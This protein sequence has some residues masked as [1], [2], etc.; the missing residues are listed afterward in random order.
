MARSVRL[1][2]LCLGIVLFGSAC[3]GGADP[4]AGTDPT[5]DP[6]G[7]NVATDDAPSSA[8]EGDFCP[9]PD[10]YLRGQLTGTV[11]ETL[12]WRS[13]AMEC[14]GSAFDAD[15]HLGWSHDISADLLLQIG[16][17]RLTPD[18]NG[19]G[20]SLPARLTINVVGTDNASYVGAA[21][22]CVV[23]ITRNEVAQ[24]HLR[25]IEG[26]ASCEP[27]SQIGGEGEITMDG[28]LAFANYV[29]GSTE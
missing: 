11:T 23:T 1:G 2:A 14:G 6:G 26:T 27:I 18:S 29:P 16:L 5:A 8:P 10:A 12:D 20:T 25:F 22:G 28:E 3:G 4:D 9:G 13:S 19:L 7:G 15:I 24:D 17:D 21:D